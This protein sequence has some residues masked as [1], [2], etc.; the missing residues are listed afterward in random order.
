MEMTMQCEE[1]S[2]YPQTYLCDSIRYG[3]KLQTWSINCW[4]SRGNESWTMAMAQ[5]L[6]VWDQRTQTML[7]LPVF[8][9]NTGS[10]MFSGT[11]IFCV[12]T[13]HLEMISTQKPEIRAVSFPLCIQ[14]ILTSWK[15]V[16]FTNEMTWKETK[17][18]TL[19]RGPCPVV[20]LFAVSVYWIHIIKY[21]SF[22]GWIHI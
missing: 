4:N 11:P 2:W 20:T 8:H 18:K 7:S 12:H 3:M 14:G 13:S 22:L 15:L 6:L 9:P 21:V 17:P 1:E 5:H 16:S 10:E 19:F